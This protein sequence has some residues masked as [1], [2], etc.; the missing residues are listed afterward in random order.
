MNSNKLR[1]IVAAAIFVVLSVGLIAGVS[2]GT[3]SGF[4]W[5]TFSA[6]CPLGALATMIATKTVVPRAVVSI[7]IM[8]VLVLAVGRAFCGWVCPVPLLD[9][10][11]GFFRSPKKRTALEQAKRSEMLGIAKSELG[12]AA[13]SPERAKRVEGSPTAA[14]GAYSHDCG[15]CSSCKEVRAKLDSRHY[16]LGGALLSTAIFGFPV[17]CLVCPIGLTFATVLVVW[18]LFAAGDMT[19]SVVPAVASGGAGVLAQVVHAVLPDGGADEPRVAL[20]QDVAAGHRRVEVPGDG[21]RRSVQQVRHRVRGRYQPAASR[22]R[23]AHSGRLHAM[24]SLCGR[25]S[26]EGGQHAVFGEE[27]CGASGKHG[28]AGRHRREDGRVMDGRASER[29]RSNRSIVGVLDGVSS[30]AIVVHRE[31]CAKVRNRNVACLKCADACTSGCIALV[32]GELRVDAAKCIGC[33]TCAT[34]CPTSALEARNPSDAQLAQA[35]LGARVGDEVVVACEQL[36]R[37]AGGL[38]DEGH[39]ANVVCLGRVDESLTSGLAVEGV[40]RIRLACGDCSR[41]E[42]EHGVATA[43]LVA[44]TSNALF[45]AWGSDAR[46]QV[47]EGVPAGAC[48]EGVGPDG[49]A[50]AVAAYFA[51]RRG[52]EHM[53]VSSAV[54]AAAAPAALPR[55]TKDGTLPHFVPDRREALLDNL[56]QLGQPVLPSVATRLWGC[57]VIDGRACSSCR[58]C[59]TFCPTGAIR[60]FDNDDGTLGVY[61]Y[62]GECVKCGSCRDVCP[63]NAIELLDEVRPAYLLEGA[64]HRYAMTPRPV[65]LGTAQQMVDTMRLRMQGSDIFER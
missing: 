65:E 31:R 1:T 30:E 41:C 7:V 8:A 38:L 58:M 36:R 52:N 55:V 63:E 43:R 18:R 15:S 34:V 42:Q 46:V 2:M 62:P 29:S 3:L 19:W 9:R 49:A 12:E 35:C 6:L 11:R 59:A 56:A 51:E 39:V 24:P 13:A 60:K 47:V 45:E 32:D 16:V 53:A 28:R 27:G 5:E 61:H 26:G 21:E 10:V 48:V 37:A 54:P 23:R 22:F 50:A 33:G 4:G 64:V 20:Q 25:V 44:A 40:R 14:D 57:V 17:F